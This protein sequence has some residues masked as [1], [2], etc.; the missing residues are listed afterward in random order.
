MGPVVALRRDETT[1]LRKKKMK[2]TK[3]KKTK[4][5]TKKATFSS[6]MSVVR[7]QLPGFRCQVSV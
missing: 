2:K 4:K 6:K 7:C 5:K 1:H 3:K